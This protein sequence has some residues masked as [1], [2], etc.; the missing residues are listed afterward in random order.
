MKSWTPA[1]GCALALL[2]LWGVHLSGL[3]DSPAEVIAGLRQGDFIVAELRLPRIALATVVGLAFGAAGCAFQTLL[4]N[5]LASPDIIGISSSASVAGVLGVT[6]LGLNQWATS[7]FSLALSLLV[8][9]V[10]F[11]LAWRGGRFSG[12]RLILI[13]L[14]IAALAQAIVSWVLSTASAQD[15]PSAMRWLTGSL[16]SASLATVW[17]VAL[18]VAVL[19]PVLLTQR[20]YL[21]VLRFGDDTALGLGV[22][23]TRTRVLVIVS[24]VV[25]IA[26]ATAAGGPIAF[27]A[28][29]SGPIA[30]RIA[31]SS[32]PPL[33]SAALV[34]AVLVALADALGQYVTTTSYPVGV[35]T[36]V[37]GAPYLLYI[38]LTQRKVRS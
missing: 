37:L 1:L 10:M 2:A 28:F 26:V 6:V 33:L 35:F 24:A 20:H 14:G 30:L 3:Q 29:L 23:V 34:G 13:G 7:L 4:R 17:P 16:N 11:A 8:A 21:D 22:P 31:G 12:T 9:L 18:A 19:L 15:L 36:G 5:Q 32:T 27:V 25:L 38:V